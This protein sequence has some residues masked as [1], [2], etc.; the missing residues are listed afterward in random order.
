MDEF[1]DWAIFFCHTRT[2]HKCV[3]AEFKTEGNSFHMRK[4]ENNTGLK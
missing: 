3:W 1:Y 4:G 2:I